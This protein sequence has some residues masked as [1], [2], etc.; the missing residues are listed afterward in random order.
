M[1]VT[2]SLETP[3][4]SD[5]ARGRESTPPLPRILDCHHPVAQLLH[6]TQM[7]DLL[8]ATADRLAYFKTKDGRIDKPKI[9]SSIS[10]PKMFRVAHNLQS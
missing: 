9:R 3:P 1:S 8:P 5:P 10:K 2:E 7:N 6:K 4:S